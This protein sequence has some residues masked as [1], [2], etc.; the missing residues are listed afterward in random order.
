MFKI[1]QLDSSHHD[2]L[3]SSHH[4]SWCWMALASWLEGYPSPGALS[5]LNLRCGGRYRGDNFQNITSWRFCGGRDPQLAGFEVGCYQILWNCLFMRLSSGFFLLVK[6]HQ[7]SKVCGVC[8]SCHLSPSRIGN[9]PLQPQQ[10]CMMM[11]AVLRSHVAVFVPLQGPF[12]PSWFAIRGIPDDSVMIQGRQ[13]WQNTSKPAM[14]ILVCFSS[15]QELQDREGIINGDTQ[16]ENLF[17]ARCF[18]GLILGAFKPK[19]RG[20]DCCKHNLQNF[21]DFCWQVAW[22]NERRDGGEL[23][24]WDVLRCPEFQVARLDFCECILIVPSKCIETL[25]QNAT[26]GIGWVGK[27]SVIQFFIGQV[28]SRPL[29]FAGTFQWQASP[30]ARRFRSGRSW[31]TWR[32]G[33]CMVLP[34]LLR[35][36]PWNHTFVL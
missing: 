36:W 18:F 17:E 14:P 16:A 9:D 35:C 33:F 8:R 10:L 7:K 6:K 22:W 21:K 19:N 15:L 32:H 34:A 4:D 31:S 1:N 30:A 24:L 26:H 29:V 3:D 25:G 5:S 23:R 2:Q 27:G 11:T 20:A 12:S 28:A 13:M